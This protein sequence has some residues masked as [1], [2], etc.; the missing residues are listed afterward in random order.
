MPL[1]YL[2]VFGDVNVLNVGEQIAYKNALNVAKKVYIIVKT[3]AGRLLVQKI[4]DLPQ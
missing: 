2:P 3:D 4:N 1:H